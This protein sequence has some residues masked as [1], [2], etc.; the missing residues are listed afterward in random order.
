[1]STLRNYVQ[2]FGRL[3]NDPESK[4]FNENKKMVKFSL[5]TNE[6]FRDKDGERQDDTQWHNIIAFGKNAD[7]AEKYLKKGKEVA[8]S[9]KIKYGSWEDKEGNTHYITEIV[10]NDILMVGP[11]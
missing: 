10:A 2:L 11:K 5:A 4:T 8:V 7:I 9:G 3:G 1:M 6:F